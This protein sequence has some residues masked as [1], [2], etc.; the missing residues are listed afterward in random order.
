MKD[1]SIICPEEACFQD[2]RNKL[3][4]LQGEVISLTIFGGIDSIQGRI[5]RVDEGSV[6]IYGEFGK[7][8]IPIC[9]IS[10]L[11]ACRALAYV[12]NSGFPGNPGNTVS[13]IDTATDTVI[14]TITVGTVPIAVAITPFGKRIYVTNELDNSVSVICTLNNKTIETITVGNSPLDVAF[15]P[16]GKLAYVGNFDDSSISVIGTRSNKV[17]A[18]ITEGLGNG[19]FGIVIGNTPN[20]TRAYV[21]NVI[22]DNVSIIDANPN[23][24]TFNTVVGTV[25]VGNI[26][27]DAE[28]NP[29]GTSVYVTNAGD[30]TVSVIDTATNAV[31]TIHVGAGPSGVG[32][33]LTPLGTRAYVLNSVENTI[34]VIDA[35]PSSPTFDTVITTISKGVGEAPS[36]ADLTP[37]GRKVYVPNNLDPVVS[38]I[39]TLTNTVIDSIPVGLGPNVIDVGRVCSKI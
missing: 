28:I 5:L 9:N 19:P 21:V 38:V 18:T 34:S 13:V 23:S 1:K 39:D 8:I 33:G 24:E 30:D 22:S 27:I 12:T 4:K 15:T 7:R 29:Y 32:I 36:D 25:Q 10:S 14:D 3:E 31:T 11:D 20:G 35:E 16:D 37:D 17:I 6:I 2:L 26:P